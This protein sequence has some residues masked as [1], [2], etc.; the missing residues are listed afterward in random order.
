MN[1]EQMQKIH[2]SEEYKKCCLRETLA[3]LCFSIGNQLREEN[4]DYLRSIGLLVQDIKFFANQASA[5][6]NRYNTALKQILLT[7]MATELCEDYE[8][9]RKELYQFAGLEPKDTD[10]AD[11]S[12]INN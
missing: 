10:P 9:V 3:Y 6:F 4:D 11:C 5:T 2:D 12:A 8:K 1:K 7:D